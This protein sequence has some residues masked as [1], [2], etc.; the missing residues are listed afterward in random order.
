MPDFALL[1]PPAEGKK[2]GGNPL[3]PDLFDLRAGGTFNYFSELNPERR[4]L[5]DALQ[6]AISGDG[7][8]DAAAAIL[9]LQPPALAAAVAANMSVYDAPR[10]ATLDRYA[11]G[12]LYEALEF[13]HLPTGARRRFLEHTV[14]VSGLWGLLRPDDLIPDYKLPIDASVPGIG[15]VSAY[16]KPSLSAVLNRMVEGRVVWDLLPGVHADA[17]DDTRVYARRVRVRFVTEAADGERTG[18]SH[19]IK[20][21]RGRLA[22]HLVREGAERDDAL[23]SWHAPDGFRFDEAATVRDDDARSTVL[24]YVRR[25]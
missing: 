11:P 1:L 23:A 8:M 2:P 10:M 24:T 5:I 22:G 21:L 25:A 15:K 3:A 6:G 18:V 14:I 12:V 4:R 7:G 17:W 20:D 19:G 9:G 13:A 16:W